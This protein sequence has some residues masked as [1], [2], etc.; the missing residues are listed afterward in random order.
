V[1]ALELFREFYYSLGMPLRSVIEYQIRRRGGSPSEI[2]ERPWL[3]F[4]Y[5]AL[6]M[7]QHNAELIAMLFADF[8]RRYRVDSKV[9]VGALRSPEGWRRFVEHVEGL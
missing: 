8:V 5:V 9:A 4:H 6:A 7:G 1:D 3:L 2:F